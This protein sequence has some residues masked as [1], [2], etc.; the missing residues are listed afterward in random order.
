MLDDFMALKQIGNVYDK[1]VCHAAENIVARVGML[2]IHHLNNAQVA[3]GNMGSDD[4]GS[5]GIVLT[6]D[7]EG[8]APAA[9]G[10]KSHKEQKSKKS[11]S[12]DCWKSS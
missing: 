11:P 5:D 9:D 7:E 12:S 8:L 3:H 1:E 4:D 2:F 10:A 6:D